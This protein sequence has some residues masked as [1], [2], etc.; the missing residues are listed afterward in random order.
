MAEMITFNQTISA[1]PERVFDAFITPEDLLQ[2][3]RASEDWNTP[4]AETD[5]R[6][7]GRFNIGF[8]DPTG[9]HSFD[10]TGEYTELNRP[11]RLAYTI[12]DGRKVEIDFADSGD[13]S[14]HVTWSFEPESE[15]PADM[16]RDGW[17]AQLANLGK[18]LG[19]G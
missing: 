7:G 18:Y 3:H 14:T 9:E 4:H 17:A 6:V 8:G 19:N 11:N 13:G 5:P 16:Q 12:D 2:W 10:F 15:F 1:A